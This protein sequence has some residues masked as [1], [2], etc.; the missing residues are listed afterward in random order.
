MADRLPVVTNFTVKNDFMREVENEYAGQTGGSKFP[1]V[2][3]Y[4][5]KLWDSAMLPLEDD[6]RRIVHDEHTAGLKAALNEREAQLRQ[7]IGQINEAEKQNKEEKHR[8]DIL[9]QLSMQQMQSMN[10][11]D[12]IIAKKDDELASL[13]DD[14]KT[15]QQQGA[16]GGGAIMAPPTDNA[17][18]TM[19]MPPFTG[20]V[21]QGKRVPAFDLWYVEFKANTKTMTKQRQLALLI[22]HL[23]GPAKRA[24]IAMTQET[25]ENFD[26]LVDALKIRYPPE[27][28]PRQAM[29]AFNARKHEPTETI[30]QF[31]N[32]LRT[33]LDVAVHIFPEESRTIFYTNSLRTRLLEALSPRIQEK[34]HME[35]M[36]GKTPEEIINCGRGHE[37]QL[38]REQADTPVLHKSQA[39]YQQQ[40]L[41]GGPQQ[42]YQQQQP[43]YSGPQQVFYNSQ[44]N[45]QRPQQGSGPQGRGAHRQQRGG[46]QTQVYKRWCS[47]HNSSTHSW[48]DCQA[49]PK[50]Q[51]GEP[52]QGGGQQQGK[53]PSNQAHGA[54]DARVQKLDDHASD[55][56]SSFETAKYKKKKNR[57]KKNAKNLNGGVGQALSEP[58][59]E[60]A[61]PV[62]ERR[63][64]VEGCETFNVPF[65][66]GAAMNVISEARLREITSKARMSQTEYDKRKCPPPVAVMKVIEGGKYQVAYGFR[67]EVRFPRG[68]D[69]PVLFC[70]IGSNSSEL[71]LGMPALRTLGC[72]F[73]YP[74]RL[75]VNAL[76]VERLVD[77]NQIASR[78]QNAPIG[79]AAGK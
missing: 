68:K 39:Y 14:I 62:L 40:T 51:G 41:Y 63:M 64:Y 9:Q 71:L 2:E 45:G 33:L 56:S 54:Q 1:Q 65:D 79:A 17:A 8:F 48:E 22:N 52:Q 20:E 61:C 18:V 35:E 70:V 46:R 36:E 49:R 12:T 74:D 34:M 73:T 27:H 42:F 59:M 77:K 5:G 3:H 58:K 55:N 43:Q 66:S 75:N 13:R 37:R 4:A 57:E 69:F 78:T 11:K 28:T 38:M 7:A 67:L 32:D 47:Y 31:A 21:K 29:T 16:N 60:A 6:D 19:R 10:A 72:S 76:Q 26:M 23:D 44:Q 15:M 24:L 30:D 53:G 25:Q 50:Q